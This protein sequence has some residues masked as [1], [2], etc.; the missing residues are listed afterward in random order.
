MTSTDHGEITGAPW[1]LATFTTGP[2]DRIEPSAASSTHEERERVQRHRVLQAVLSIASV[3]G[4]GT[5]S[6]ALILRTAEVP[7]RSFNAWFSTAEEAFLVAHARCLEQLGGA[8]RAAIETGG[9]PEHRLRQ[10]LRAAVEHLVADPARADAMVL[11]AHVAGRRALRQNEAAIEALVVEVHAL[12][13][14]AGLADPVAHRMALTG[15]GALREVIRARIVRGELH[16]LPTVV[17]ELVEAAFPLR[18]I[19]GAGG[20][21]GTPSRVAMAA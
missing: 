5:L 3:G 14:Q 6:T 15:V 2:R 7:R 21:T 13:V 4:Y 20:G 9:G 12:L 8:V 11:E 16:T 19:D 1:E 10:G 18:V 17:G